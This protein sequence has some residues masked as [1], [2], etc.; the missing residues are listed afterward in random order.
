ME[1]I[2]DKTGPLFHFFVNPTHIFAQNPDTDQL[3][4]A[5]KQNQ[6]H[7]SGVPQR[8][9]ESENLQYCIG[10]TEEKRAEGCHEPGLSAQRQSII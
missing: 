3:D 1:C 4:P 2:D 5:K 6:N 7:N 10:E 8:E 9:R